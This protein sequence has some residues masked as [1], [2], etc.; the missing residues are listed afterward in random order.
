[1]FLRQTLLFL[2]QRKEMAFPANFLIRHAGGNFVA[3]EERQEA[4][5]IAESLLAR[6]FGIALDF[7][8]ED[9]S[10]DDLSQ[11]ASEEYLA[12]LEH[13]SPA[14]NLAGISIRLSQLGLR[15]DE[16]RALRHTLEIAGKASQN[17]AYLRIGMEDSQLTDRTL[18]I[19]QAVDRTKPGSACVVVQSCLHRCGADMETLC[20]AGIPI[21]LVKGSYP[22][23]KELAFQDPEEIDLHFMRLV[24]HLMRD[25]TRPSIGTHS[26]KLIEYCIDMAFIFGLEKSD[27][28]F[29]MFYGIRNDLQEKLLEDGYR[30]R[31]HIPYG[32]HWYAYLLR[33]LAEDPT[34]LWKFLFR[35]QE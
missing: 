17:G 4:L 1:M 32:E 16:N 30:V 19:A 35:K 25:G 28:E 8:G 23:P 22:E 12:A 9:P 27:Y 26:E 7:L 15:F 6:G 24:E 33:R 5:D 18:K 20:T 11:K 31:V 3:G 29:Q 34:L 2:S 13:L 14:G 21:C 10:D